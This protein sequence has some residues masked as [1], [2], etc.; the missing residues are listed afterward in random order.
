MLA[1]GR[2]APGQS[3]VEAS[4][5]DQLKASRSVGREALRYLAGEGVVEI[6]PRENPALVYAG[7]TS[8]LLTGDADGAYGVWLREIENDAAHLDSSSR[9][10]QA[11]DALRRRVK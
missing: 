6:I 7:M 9:R 4:L 11:A 2:L 5:T 1:S 3:L 8:R 10:D